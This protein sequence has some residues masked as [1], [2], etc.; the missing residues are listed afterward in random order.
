MF[1]KED[2]NAEFRPRQNFSMGEADFN[3]FIRQRNQLVLANVQQY[4]C[5]QTQWGGRPYVLR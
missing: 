5:K 4:M 1:E 2:K 3:K